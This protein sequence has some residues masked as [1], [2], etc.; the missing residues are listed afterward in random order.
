MHEIAPG[1]YAAPKMKKSVRE[2][3]W[4]VLLDWSE[5]IPEDGG[6]VLLWKSPKAP[7]GL[8]VRVLGWPKKELVEYEGMWLTFKELTQ[9]H[10]SDELEK[11][12]T[13]KEPPFDK[14]DPTV[15]QF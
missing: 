8:G 3:L 9:S 5:L 2:R 12:L 4:R 15:D 14:D 1:V 10:D 6:V 11:L 13:S 7:S